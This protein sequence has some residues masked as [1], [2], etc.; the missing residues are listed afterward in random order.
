MQGRFAGRGEGAILL[1]DWEHFTPLMADAYTRGGG[2]VEEDLRPIYA[3]TAK[4]W[5]AW[6]WEHIEAGPI[7]LPDDRAAVRHEGFRLVPEGAFY[8]V[9]APPVTEADADHRLDVW[10]GERVHILGYDLPQTTVRAGERLVLTLY[11]SVP[12]PLE[13]IWMPYAEL[14]LLEARWT[15]D[16]RVLTNQWLPGEIV[17]ERYELPI[18]YGLPP[19]EYPLRLG[20]ADLTGGRGDLELSTGGETVELATITV[21]PNPHAPSAEVRKRALANLDNQVA[22]MSARA[23]SQTSLPDCLAKSKAVW[24]EPLIVRAGDALRLILKWRALT[25]PR[26][27]ATIFIHLIDGAGRPV[28]GHD[29]TP[30]GGSAPTYLWFPKWLPG[31][32]YT[33]PYRLEIPADT[34]PGE[35]WLEVGMY[36]M[37]SLRRFPVVDLKGNLAGDRVILGSVRVE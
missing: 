31:Q 28:V 32:T 2:L 3:S 26:D 12:E 35:Y 9:E 21:T 34:P 19:G 18:S 23:C 27:S 11:Q 30:L 24:E 4:S 16:S 7:Y 1:S 29:Y 20:Y 6:V 25:S 10:A 37:T 17:V 8:R 13:A 15:T 33:D 5:P 14:G 36:G 22:L